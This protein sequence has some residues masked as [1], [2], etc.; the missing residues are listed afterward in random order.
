MS[1]IRKEK[2]KDKWVQSIVNIVNK[3]KEWWISFRALKGIVRM[4]CDWMIKLS[5]IWV[6]WKCDAKI[7][8]HLSVGWAH[9]TMSRQNLLL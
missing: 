1:L 7:V 5:C 2:N 6:A 9:A 3:K 8:F 4:I